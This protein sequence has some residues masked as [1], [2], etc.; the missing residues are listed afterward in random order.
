M[1]D[2]PEGIESLINQYLYT[3]WL[4]RNYATYNN[5]VAKANTFRAKLDKEIKFM[6]STNC[7]IA[8]D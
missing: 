5:P 3:I 4:H 8:I 7:I 1:K 2:I 6:Q